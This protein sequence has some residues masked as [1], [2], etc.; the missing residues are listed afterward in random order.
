MMSHGC[1]RGY[2]TD[3]VDNVNADWDI[4]VQR[5]VSVSYIATF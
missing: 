4:Q 3:P 5:A 1:V 2:V